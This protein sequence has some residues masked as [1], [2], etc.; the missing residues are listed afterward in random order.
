M[1]IACVFPIILFVGQKV[2]NNESVLEI[3]FQQQKLTRRHNFYNI[4]L[5]LYKKI[6]VTKL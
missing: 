3:S 6:Y 5:Y 2:N 1:E 4:G